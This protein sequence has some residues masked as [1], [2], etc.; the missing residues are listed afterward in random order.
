MNRLLVVE[1]ERSM[2]DLLA[3]M[4]RKEGYAVETVDSGLEAKHRLDRDEVYDL[5]I[6]DISMPKMTGLELLRHAR[7][8]APD[9]QVIL[10][11]AFGSKQVAIEALNEG[12]SY[13]VEKPFDLDELKAVVQ[14][15]L[16]QKRIATEVATLKAENTSLQAELQDK[17]ERIAQEEAR[18]VSALYNE[19]GRKTIQT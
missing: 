16:D 5:I 13:Y 19:G 9:T 4:L 2:R 17:H 3:L 7:S 1:D 8:Q 11:T 10:M 6:S 12:A 14:K 15:T 18:W